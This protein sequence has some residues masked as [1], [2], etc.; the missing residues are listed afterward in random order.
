MTDKMTP[1]ELLAALEAATGPRRAFGW[2]GR[3][4][5]PHRPKNRPTR[6]KSMCSCVFR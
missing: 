5:A 3:I 1:A 4:I 2:P 6:G